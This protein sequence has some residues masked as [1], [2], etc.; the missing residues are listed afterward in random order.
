MTGAPIDLG[1][2]LF[3]RGTGRWYHGSSYSAKVVDIRESDDTIKIRYLDGGFKRFKR[4]ELEKLIIDAGASRNSIV[5]VLQVYELSHDQY[6][7]G[8]SRL[9]SSKRVNQIFLFI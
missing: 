5:D 4:E 2:N 9:I 7:A 8:L 6:D 1:N 3:I